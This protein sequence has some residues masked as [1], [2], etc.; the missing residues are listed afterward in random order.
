MERFEF[1]SD[2]E[3]KD[4]KL[5]GFFELS[6]L[7][8]LANEL[9]EEVEDL[10]GEKQALEEKIEERGSDMQALIERVKEEFCRLEALDCP[11]YVSPNYSVLEE[12]Q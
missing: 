4:N 10:E 1:C 12:F 2:G 11:E 7:L 3:I 6:H 9:H 8:S 5:N